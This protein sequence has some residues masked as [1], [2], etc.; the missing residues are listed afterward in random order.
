VIELHGEQIRLRQVDPSRFKEF[1]TKNVGSKGK[2][3]IIL[4]SP[5]GKHWYIQSYRFNLP[6]YA[7]VTDVLHDARSIQRIPIVQSDLDK[8]AS[9][10]R[11][12][13]RSVN[14]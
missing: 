1:R 12:Y 5:D 11:K 7:S 13:F 14:G 3:S 6:D 4:G 9:L 10:A 2:L 8:I